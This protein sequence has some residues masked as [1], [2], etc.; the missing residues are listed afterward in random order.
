MV[1]GIIFFFKFTNQFNLM[2]IIESFIQDVSVA[3]KEIDK[4][5]G[6]SLSD[7]AFNLAGSYFSKAIFI[8][9]QSCRNLRVKLDQSELSRIGSAHFRPDIQVRAFSVEQ[10]R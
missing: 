7:F 3:A 8:T 9:F 5:H 2:L 6:F 1:I 10:V 4:D